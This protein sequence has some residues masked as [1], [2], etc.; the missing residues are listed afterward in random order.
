M[1]HA[2]G[3]L[4]Q[5]VGLANELHVAVL[6]AVVHHL[7]KMAGAVLA[8]PVAAWLVAGLGTDGLWRECD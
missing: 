5:V 4:H 6:N 3:I 1:I 8:H 2:Q 7:D